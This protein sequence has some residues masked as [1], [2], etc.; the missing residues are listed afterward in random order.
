VEHRSKVDGVS[1]LCLLLLPKSNNPDYVPMD[2]FTY[3][4]E[5]ALVTYCDGT[6]KVYI[7]ELGSKEFICKSLDRG[8]PIDSDKH[9]Y[10]IKIFGIEDGDISGASHLYQNDHG[11]VVEGI[12][13][14][15]R[16]LLPQGSWEVKPL[17]VALIVQLQGVS[18]DN[19]KCPNDKKHPCHLVTG[20]QFDF[21]QLKQNRDSNPNFMH[22]DIKKLA[23]EIK[24]GPIELLIVPTA[25]VG[26]IVDSEAI[27]SSVFLRTD[28]IYKFLGSFRGS[29]IRLGADI[30]KDGLPE[31]IVNDSSP[32]Y[33]QQIDY[34]K[35]YPRVELLMSYAHY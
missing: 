20:T 13:T 19:Y 35:I 34:Y 1:P 3:G 15:S 9:K 24:S 27:V 21:E 5:K 8:K 6:N 22:A 17:P 11:E 26:G 12:Y 23:I 10:E 14:V 4:D 16:T 2:L 7:Y 30:D 32:G 33:F 25:I 18:K 31:L 28:E 29:L